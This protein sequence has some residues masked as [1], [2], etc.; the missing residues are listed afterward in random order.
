M[1]KYQQQ[2]LALAG[3]A[4]S[5]FLV[6]QLAQHGFVAHDKFATAINSL[7]LT[8]PKTTEEVYGSVGKLNL[9]MQVLQEILT[10][11][12]TAFTPTAVM[13]YQLGLLFLEYKLGK[14]PELLTEISTGLAAIRTKYLGDNIAE[15][16]NAIE[17]ISRLYLGTISTLSF[18]IQVRGEMSY[19]KNTQVA[20]K[21]RV[22]LFAGI[23]SA[24]LWRQVGGKRWHL[25]FRRKQIKQ[26]INKF[27]YKL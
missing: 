11:T 7:F 26:D 24:V 14:K 10:G 27:L 21:V 9:G 4:Q 3:I 22:L 2:T 23:R 20:C 16:A 19:L 6:H 17:D 18:R 13:R 25:L 5:A 8:N 1:E 12:A 15:N